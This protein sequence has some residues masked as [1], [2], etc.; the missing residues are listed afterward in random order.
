MN[1]EAAAVE[2]KV[3]ALFKFVATVSRQPA[4][5]VREDFDT[6]RE[7]G[8]SDA[9]ITEGA[10]RFALCVRQ[11]LLSRHRPRRRLLAKAHSM[12]LRIRSS[13]MLTHISLPDLKLQGEGETYDSRRRP[14][15][16]R[17]GRLARE[18]RNG[19]RSPRIRETTRP[20]SIAATTS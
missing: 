7:A 14:A 6:V 13:R 20:P 18:R 8:W 2:P 4:D 12:L 3:M 15:V 5:I 17:F 9:E 10:R 19:R 1:F 16:S 11:P